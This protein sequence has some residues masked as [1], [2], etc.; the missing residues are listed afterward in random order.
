MMQMTPG[1]KLEAA[2]VRTGNYASDS[3]YGMTGAFKLTGP[4]GRELI[5]MANTA[6]ALSG[7]WEH[8]SV[9]L[10]SR[11]PNWQEMCFV[12]DLFWE[13]EECVVQFHVPASKHINLHPYTLHMWRRPG[14][15]FELP[16]EWLV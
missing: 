1:E 15:E 16:P 3:S 8:V 9:S 11:P 14:R 4:C 5:I 2:R 6:N 13:S 7:G 10:S 12:K